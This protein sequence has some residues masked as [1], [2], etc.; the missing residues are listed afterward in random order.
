MT[1]VITRVEGSPLS[2]SGAP[3]APPRAPLSADGSVAYRADIDGLRALAILLVVVYH[4]WL[5]RVSGGVD[6]FLMISAFFLT[7][8]F[9]RRMK[10]G[11]RMRVGTYWL[12][13]FRRLL[14]AA[15]VT[16]LGVLATAYF[17]YPPT[18]W[19]TLWRQTWAS[20]FYVQN[21][22]LAF[23]EVDYYARDEAVPSALQHFWSLSVQGQVFVLW[24]LIF[25]VVA[26]VVRRTR[27][28]ADLLLAVVFGVIFAASLAFSIYETA[29]NQMFA[30]FDTRTRLWEFAAGSLVALAIPFFRAP[31]ALRAVLGWVGVIGIVACGI[32]IDVRGGFPGYLAL[33]PVLCTAAVI[34]GG[35]APARGGP[36]ALLSS[37]PVRFLGR[38]AYALY[39]VHWPVLITW[40]IV[41]EQTS[42][43]PFAGLAIIVISF[44]LAR[45]VAGGVE[46]PMRRLT[47]LDARPALGGIVIVACIATVAVPLTLWQIAERARVEAAA[48]EFA[49]DYPGAAALPFGEGVPVREDV[50]LLPDPTSIDDEWVALESDCAGAFRPTSPL[51]A[52]TCAQLTAPG[53]A[54]GTVVVVGD[55]HAQQWMGAV[56]PIAREQGW[57]V[58]ALLKGGCSFAVDEPPVPGSRDCERWRSAAD[59]Y[60]QRLQPDVVFGMATKTE[61]GGPGERALGGLEDTVEA[62]ESTGA[63]VVL[64][65]DNP[66]F[67]ED[68][69][70]CVVENG[71][72]SVLCRTD[73]SD[74]LARFDPAR[75][76]AG[77]AHLV[78][79]SDYLCPDD[80]CFPV[81]GNVAVYLD[82]NHLTHMYAATLAPLLA[83]ELTAAG[84]IEAG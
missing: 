53:E 2:T 3:A 8:S 11:A 4:V 66:R 76:A 35:V 74:A 39:L 78:D 23:S 18:L 20:L 30:Y 68:I 81:I 31:A 65:R 42:V 71:A 38:D 36:T 82:D 34:L 1:P 60:I 16:L 5:G 44:V 46:N 13:K 69:F 43:G 32:V 50:P 55:S 25:L 48:A 40:L 28:R 27:I 84:V 56:L 26:F 22:E 61:P 58:I 14:P 15:V 52:R 6:V 59:R 7:A 80:V 73:R 70:E 57:N 41:T 9:A 75:G 83:R 33:W 17:L 64:F 12:R 10:H 77:N 29:T 63:E 79:L 72:D 51:V 49:N 54:S 67:T 21:W 37:R 47:S 19:P 62:L 24:P 45:I